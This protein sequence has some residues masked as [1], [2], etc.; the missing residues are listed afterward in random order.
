MEPC[1]LRSNTDIITKAS[2]HGVQRYAGRGSNLRVKD[3]IAALP[4]VARNDNCNNI[5]YDCTSS[6][7]HKSQFANLKSK[8]PP[9]C[10]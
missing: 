5:R 1:F 4:S 2:L 9:V 7:N 3:E 6:L 8:I 10:N